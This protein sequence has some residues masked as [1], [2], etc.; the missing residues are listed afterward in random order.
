MPQ[1]ALKLNAEI[2]KGFIIENLEERKFKCK[3]CKFSRII[4]KKT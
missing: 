1:R 3:N 4:R 2:Y